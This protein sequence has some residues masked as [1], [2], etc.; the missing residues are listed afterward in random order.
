MDMLDHHLFDANFPQQSAGS[1]DGPS[2]TV[3]GKF[4]IVALVVHLVS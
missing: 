4:L 2:E 1:R 3:Y